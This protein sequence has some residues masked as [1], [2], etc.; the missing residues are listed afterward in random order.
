MKFRTVL[1]DPPWRYNDKL[2]MS[3]VKRGADANYPTMSV[4]EIC[5]LWTREHRTLA[6]HQLEDDAFLFL[7]STNPFLLNGV[8][9]AV[10]RAWNFKEK[11][12]ITWVKGRAAYEIVG[13]G[14]FHTIIPKLVLRTGLGHYTR[15]TTEPLILATR[16]APKVYVKDDGVNNLVLE[17]EDEVLLASPSRH[18]K[19]PEA[20]YQLIERL[21]PGPYLELFSRQQRPGWTCWGN[22]L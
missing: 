22:E 15:G 12:I 5:A 20:S 7:W 10:C 2:T 14:V 4:E 13:D 16:G 19:K 11:Q 1:A 8:A 18:S 17:P 9:T 6:G 3:D 21:C